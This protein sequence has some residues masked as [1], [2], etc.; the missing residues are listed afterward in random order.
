[1]KNFYNFVDLTVNRKEVERAIKER[2]VDYVRDS[3]TKTFADS[4]VENILS[5]VSYKDEIKYSVI[6]G[7]ND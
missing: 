7:K 2:G 6:D 5:T 1:M 4:F 3:L